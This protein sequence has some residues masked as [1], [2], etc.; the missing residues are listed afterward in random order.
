MARQLSLDEQAR[1]AFCRD[2]QWLQHAG[3]FYEHVSVT[4]VNVPHKGF[5]VRRDNSDE[6][7]G[8]SKVFLHHRNSFLTHVFF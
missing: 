4:H 2:T 7:T 6:R 1:N 8:T 3:S 5:G